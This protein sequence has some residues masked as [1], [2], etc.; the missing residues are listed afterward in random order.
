MSIIAREASVKDTVS[1]TGVVSA[2]IVSVVMMEVTSLC[3]GSGSLS[4]SS[5]VLSSFSHVLWE[6]ER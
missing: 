1:T 2:I 3:R 6:M 5:A 4:V